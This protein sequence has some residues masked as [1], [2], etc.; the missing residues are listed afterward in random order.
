[1]DLGQDPGVD[2]VA[3]GDLVAAIANGA[4]G[5]LKSRRPAGQRAAVAAPAERHAVKP[6]AGFEVLEIET[7]DVVTFDDVRIA[8]PHETPALGEQRGFVET[9]AAD[10][11]TKAGGIGQGDGD[12]AI[13]GPG[14]ARKLE[15]LRRHDLDVQ[16]ETPEIGERETAERSPPGEQ[17][18]LVHRVGQ[19]EIGRLGSARP[20]PRSLSTAITRGDGITP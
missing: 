12:D 2:D 13:A 6:G 5:D 9:I 18:V 1:M 7:E 4:L 17:Q 3:A 19:E 11:V 14:R 16:R 15:T 10:H 8:L 20:D